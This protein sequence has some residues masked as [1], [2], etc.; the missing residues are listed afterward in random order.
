MTHDV[1]EE[2]KVFCT[3]QNKACDHSNWKY[4]SKELYSVLNRLIILLFP[5]NIKCHLITNVD[6]FIQLQTTKL[7]KK[8]LKK[9]TSGL[10]Y[11]Q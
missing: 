11:Y 7:L 2:E 10:I 9:N 5:L 6:L 3:V 8:L 1:K 4:F